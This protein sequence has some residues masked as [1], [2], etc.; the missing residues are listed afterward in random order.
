MSIFISI[1]K[2]L[3]RDFKI[4]PILQTFQVVIQ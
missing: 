3:E 2:L 4:F 1:V